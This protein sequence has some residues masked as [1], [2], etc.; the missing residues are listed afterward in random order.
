MSCSC[1]LRS[2]SGRSC[3]WTAISS[4]PHGSG[5]PTRFT[6]WP[7]LHQHTA[8]WSPLYF[9]LT[10]VFA[11]CLRQFQSSCTH[12]ESA[13]ITSVGSIAYVDDALVPAAYYQSI[14]YP[15]IF[16]FLHLIG[17]VFAIFAA[18]APCSVT[19]KDSF[20]SPEG[21]SGETTFV[22]SWLDA[23]TP[24]ENLLLGRACR[25]HHP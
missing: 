16:L 4:L 18:V 9:M 2:R 3:S 25:H 12:Y 7:R 5:M 19:A 23:C 14:Q 20:L 8:L 17:L 11:C 22:G 6:T 10:I 13:I 24:T 1:S 15:A 21:S